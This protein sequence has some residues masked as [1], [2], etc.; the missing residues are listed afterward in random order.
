MWLKYLWTSCFQKLEEKFNANEA[1]KVQVQRKL[2]VVLSLPSFFNPL[3]FVCTNQDM[4]NRMQLNGPRQPCT[5][6]LS[7]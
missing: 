7:N 4:K 3:H 5:L 6:P 2:K 1:Q